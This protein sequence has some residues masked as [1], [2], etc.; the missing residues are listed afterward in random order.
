[1]PK[2]RSSYSQRSREWII[3]V[4]LLF[5]SALMT[6]VVCEGILT[7]LD[8]TVR[9]PGCR[10]LVR[11]QWA[12]V[13]RVPSLAE[14]FVADSE[15]GS[16]FNKPDDP[17]YNAQGF[18]DRDDFSKVSG[19][20]GL[21]I[22]L[23]GDSHSWGAAAVNDGS[24]SGFTDL[25]Q[26]K[27]NHSIP[28]GALLWN[29][30]IPGIGQ[31]Q[32]LIHLKTYFPLLDPHIVLVAMCENDFSDNMRPIGF[33][34]VYEDYT[35][36]DRYE[37]DWNSFK[38]LSPQET[39]LRAKGYTFEHGKWWNCL[40]TASSLTRAK[41]YLEPKPLP[42]DSDE[43]EF[44]SR[45]L[46]VTTE[47]FKEIQDYVEGFGRRL[48]VMVIPSR[49]TIAQS[50]ATWRSGGPVHARAI[51]MLRDL[52]ITTVDLKPHVSLSDYVGPPDN[53]LDKSGHIKASEVLYEHIH[54]SFDPNSEP[55]AVSDQQSARVQP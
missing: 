29:T 1:M 8:V 45:G 13:P 54:T 51:E 9:L 14:H 37:H 15:S 20:F 10:P 2:Q 49:E 35:W 39:W 23:L 26:D 7:I 44:T 28:G 24:D 12:F 38:L 52:S 32:E 21:R 47:L 50:G 40:R 6:L 4:S 3:N 46:A 16:R 53:H 33:H 43:E 25:L 36:A 11:S 31:K 41:R 5:A 48:V 30:G 22:L 18:R 55:S 34:Y 17:R 42:K 19:T 27:L